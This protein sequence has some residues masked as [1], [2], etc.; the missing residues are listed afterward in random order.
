MVKSMNWKFIELNDVS[1]DRGRMVVLENLNQI[2]F[3]VKRMFYIYG[4]KDYAVRGNHANRNSEFF[5]V[6]LSG[7]V[8]VEVDDGK[9]K[10]IFK[11]SSPKKALY[12]NKMVWK[13]MKNFSQ[14]AVLLCITNTLYDNTE[15]IRNIDDFYM[16]VK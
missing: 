5:M 11:L 6:C 7:S 1:D 3:E 10:E 13:T 2:P 15:Y 12:M 14:D 16:E 9:T 4:I 8:E